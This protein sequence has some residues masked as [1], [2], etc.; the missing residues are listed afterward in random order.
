M[1]SSVETRN[2]EIVKQSSDIYRAIVKKQDSKLPGYW[3]KQ[4]GRS[5]LSV[6]SNWCEGLG[7]SPGSKRCI[8]HFAVAR[9]SAYEASIQLD[10]ADLFDLR[11]KMDNVCNLI[12]ECIPEEIDLSSEDMLKPYVDAIKHYSE[13][14]ESLLAK[15]VIK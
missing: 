14:R 13:I 6:P 7:Y 15:I 4:V 2:I 8:W 9:G 11:D 12:N 1:I 3:Y 5:V 10:I